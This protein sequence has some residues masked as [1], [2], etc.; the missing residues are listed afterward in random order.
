[1]EMDE[2]EEA[3]VEME[4]DLE[5]EV[6]RPSGIPPPRKLGKRGWWL[7]PVHLQNPLVIHVEASLLESIFGPNMVLLK[8]FERVNETLLDV[9]VED[10][11]GDAEITIIGRPWHR[12]RAEWLLQ[13]MAGIHRHSRFKG[14]RPYP[15]VLITGDEVVSLEQAMSMLEVHPESGE[16]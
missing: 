9:K 14:P 4:A 11:L 10:P 3:P 12:K 8:L 13:A 6:D 2:V 15:A 16:N 7:Q 5:M 1:M